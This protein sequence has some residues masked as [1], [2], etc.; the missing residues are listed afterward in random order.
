MSD[1]RTT[2]ALHCDL[3]IHA[4]ATRPSIQPEEIPVE[5]PT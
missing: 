3:T 1:G 4:F 5:P 2:A